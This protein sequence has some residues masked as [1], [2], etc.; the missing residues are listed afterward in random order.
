[1]A[2][3]HQ[4]PRK[5]KNVTPATAKKAP[6]ATT[7][8]T[9]TPGTPVKSATGQP[10]VQETAL[11]GAYSWTH[12]YDYVKKDLRKLAIVSTVLFVAIIVAGFFI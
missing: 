8:V 9:A 4:A 7:P 12:D 3:S 1:M 2:T 10:P 5:S 6:G 11:T